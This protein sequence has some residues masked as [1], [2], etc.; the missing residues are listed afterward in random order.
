MARKCSTAL[1]EPPVAITRAMAF[2]ML[3]RVTMSRG[4]MPSRIALTSTAA[5]CATLSPFSG[6]GLAICEEPS[7][8]MPSASK[9]EDMVLAVYI[10]PQAPWLG[11][12]FFSM[13]SKSSRLILPAVKLP[14][15]S[16]GETM[17]RAWPFQKPGLMV[18]P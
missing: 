15:A 17:V 10:P 16:K 11:Q 3:L 6:S 7:S 1:V 5:D 9:A 4:R 2:S 12:A 8:D 18:P 14:T 13:P